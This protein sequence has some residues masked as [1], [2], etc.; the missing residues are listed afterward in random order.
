MYN[1][2]VLEYYLALWAASLVQITSNFHDLFAK[3][4]EINLLK[5]N[6]NNFNFLIVSEK[7]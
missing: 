1:L 6:F 5:Q 3:T 2:M 4:F 7:V